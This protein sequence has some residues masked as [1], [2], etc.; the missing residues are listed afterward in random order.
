ML[1]AKQIFTLT[2]LDPVQDLSLEAIFVKIPELCGLAPLDQ[3][4]GFLSDELVIKS[5]KSL[6]ISLALREESRL[7]QAI[8]LEESFDITTG[9]FEYK[10]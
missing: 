1:N 4:R 7:L 5:S 6:A 8:P 3:F 9:D 2:D 10:T